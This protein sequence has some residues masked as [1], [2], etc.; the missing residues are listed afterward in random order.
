M[1]T[2]LVNVGSVCGV[3]PGTCPGRV[4]A[5]ACIARMHFLVKH[6]PSPSLHHDVC[7][8]P[9]REFESWRCGDRGGRL[10]RGS[11]LSLGI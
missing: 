2:I 10:R 6:C 11:P 9:P 7:G 4:V 3:E 1:S 5:M 8:V